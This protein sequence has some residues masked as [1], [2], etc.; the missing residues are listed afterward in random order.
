MG[1]SLNDP[2]R[3]SGLYTMDCGAVIR[4]DHKGDRLSLRVCGD[5]P[6]GLTHIDAIVVDPRSDNMI[7]V[8]VRTRVEAGLPPIEDQEEVELKP[9]FHSP[10]GSDQVV[11]SKQVVLNGTN[12]TVEIVRR[13][14]GTRYER[15]VAPLGSV[16][17]WRELE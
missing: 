5:G 11:E 7:D 2:H 4:V 9:S 1:P 17:D 13:S 8:R 6:S 12:Y 16:V 15:T 14:N 3:L 10:S